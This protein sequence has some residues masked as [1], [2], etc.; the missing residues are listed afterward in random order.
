MKIY[1]SFWTGELMVKMT[2]DEY[3]YEHYENSKSERRREKHEPRRGYCGGATF[4]A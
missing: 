1:K 2:L 4:G 3:R